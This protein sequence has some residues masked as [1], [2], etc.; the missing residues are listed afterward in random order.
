MLTL[1]V[2]DDVATCF[3]GS[4]L[5]RCTVFVG[6]ADEEDTDRRLGDLYVQYPYRQGLFQQDVRDIAI[7][8]AANRTKP[9]SVNVRC[10]PDVDLGAIS[11]LSI[12][13][14]Y[15]W[16]P[17]AQQSN[18]RAKATRLASRLPTDEHLQR[19]RRDGHPSWFQ[20]S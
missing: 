8:A 3:G 9:W 13:H 10:L 6:G 18:W 12:G 20:T 7:Q 19:C 17:L 16:A 15:L 14:F 1:A 2:G 4:K 5:S 11:L